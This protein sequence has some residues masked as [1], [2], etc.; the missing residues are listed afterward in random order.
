[1]G[2]FSLLIKPVSSDCNAR[3]RYCYY[4]KSGG[5]SAAEKQHPRRMPDEVL[6]R[7]ISAYMGT[8]QD[9][10]SMVWHGGE[11]TLMPLS[12]FQKAISCQKQY[13]WKGS[14]ISNSIQ[15]NGLHVSEDLAR[16][17]GKYRFLCGVSLDGPARVHDLYRRTASNGPTH[18]K[19]LDGISTLTAGGV[20]VNA[21]VLV[22][23]GNVRRPLE[24]YQYLKDR[25]F[26][27][28]QFIPCVETAPDGSV[29]EYAIT[30]EEWGEFLIRIFNVWFANDTFK[31]SVRLFESVL[32]KLVRDTAID[33]YNS[34]ACDRYLV[35]EYNGDVYPCDFF[36]QPDYKL[37]NIMD[38]SFADIRD[39]AAY[40][41]FS[42]G[43]KKWNH[44]C[45]RCEFLRLCRGDCRKFRR[46]GGNE[47]EGL[48]LLCTGWK[49]FFSATIERFEQIAAGL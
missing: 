42:C 34:S 45:K 44:E 2:A 11:P 33:C 49:K 12:F 23:R 20:P 6:N 43:K 24:V 5:N 19:V 3:C 16:F 41:H 28:I 13:A 25:G 26:T 22:S 27:H 4:L 17:L 30:G 9:I 35:V 29:P 46:N 40:R 37:G 36:V 31:I 32:A 38:Q 10:Y 8:K 21:L 14:R 48:S 18:R 39:S 1:M 7:L 15:T 47:P